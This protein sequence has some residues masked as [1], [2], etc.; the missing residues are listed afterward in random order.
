MP[1]D[2]LYRAHRDHDL[3][4]Y[5]AEEYSSTSGPLNAFYSVAVVKASQC[6]DR[7]GPL[8]S[9]KDLA[10]RAWC[11]VCVYVCVCVCVCVRACDFA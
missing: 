10:V 2:M 11:V 4:A 6:K 3:I 7:G 8:G 5:V 9:L 1:G